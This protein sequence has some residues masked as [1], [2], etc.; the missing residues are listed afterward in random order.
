M[1]NSC[2]EDFLYS[3]VVYIEIYL[4]TLNLFYTLEGMTPPRF[5]INDGRDI[6]PRAI[7]IHYSQFY[8]SRYTKCEVFTSFDEFIMYSYT[9]STII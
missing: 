7:Q 9:D 4:Y 6:L 8:S 5:Y 2:L 1:L 3:E